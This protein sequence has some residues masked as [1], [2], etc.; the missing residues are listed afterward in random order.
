MKTRTSTGLVAMV[1]LILAPIQA[2][3]K[4]AAQAAKGPVQISFRLNKTTV[5]VGESLFYKLE[6]KNL[7]KK[8]MRVWD[9]TFKDPWVMPQ[10]CQSKSGIYFEVIGPDK[11]PLL[12]RAG[13]DHPHYDWE[14][15]GR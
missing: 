3:A 1:F 15:K 14:P 12:V 4:G 13:G 8:K 6:L 9:R 11:K 2:A 7:G 5:K 10:N